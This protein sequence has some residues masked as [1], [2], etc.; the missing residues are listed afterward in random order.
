V[1]KFLEVG[2]PPTPEAERTYNA[3]EI[4]LQKR[5]ASNWS[6]DA[7]YTYSRLRG[8]YSGLGSSDEN[9][10]LSPNVVRD[11]DLWYLNYDSHGNFLSGPLNTDRPH[12]LKASGTY[13]LPFGLNVAGFFRVMSGSPISR[14][15][16]FQS[17]DVLVEN[18]MSDGRN[19]TWS[20]LDLFV[21]QSFQPF[22]D[23]GK[24]I[25]LSFNVINLLNQ[26]TAVRTFRKMYR[27]HLPLWHEGEDPGIVLN[28]YDYEAIADEQGVTL[29]P[30]FLKAD[31]FLSPIQARFGIRFIF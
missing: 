9:G 2:L 22:A 21:S 17:M 20:Q 7:S 13:T 10:R 11:F 29:D 12:Q 23:P 19:P 26:E 5:F 14:T 18:R 1:S 24:R 28:G 6:A 27:H 16:D 4:R 31:R 25:E 3:A 15:V 30:R 8:L